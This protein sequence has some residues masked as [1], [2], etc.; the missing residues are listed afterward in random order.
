MKYF[1]LTCVFLFANLC[2]KADMPIVCGVQFGSTYEQAKVILDK[3]YNGGN[4]SYQSDKNKITYYDI[5]FAGEVFDYV[6]FEF[7]SNGVRTFLENIYFYSRFNLSD[8]KYAKAKRDRLLEEFKNKYEYRWDITDDD[9]YKHYVLGHDPFN[10]AD[11]LIIIK[12][13]KSKTKG[14]E[15]KLWTIVSYNCNGFV[16]TEDEI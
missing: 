7:S 16:K 10:Y 15:M 9:G 3:K 14:G 8:A 11:G 1:I 13:S 5:R 12:T 4:K 6:D 2:A